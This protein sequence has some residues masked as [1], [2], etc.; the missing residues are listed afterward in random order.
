MAHRFA[1]GPFLLDTRVG[2]L[3]NA[4]EPV[5]VGY[6]AI[7]LLGAFLEKPGTVLSK[8]DLVEVVWEGAAVE[9]SNLSVQI[10][11]LRKAL[12]NQP[13]GG[14]WIATIPRVGYRFAGSVKT[15]DGEAPPTA[16][17]TG[18]APSRPSIAV[19]PFANLGDDKQEDYFAD[20]FVDDLITGL[21]RIRWLSV[22]A[23]NSS[24]TYKNRPTDVRQ[25]GRELGVRYI[26]EGGVRR[27]GDRIRINAQLVEAETGKHLWADRFE[28]Q[29]DSVFDLQDEITDKVVALV[30]PNIQRV[31]IERSRRKRPGSLDAYDL[32]LR[33][34]P[35]TLSQMP[36]DAEVAIRHLEEALRFEP[37]YPAAHAMLAWC[38]EWRYARGGLA[39]ADKAKALHHAHAASGIEV[40][41][42]TALAIA[43]FVRAILSRDSN[44][45]IP[46][47]ARALE[48][49]PSCATAM[50]LGGLTHAMAGD[51]EGALK[52]AERAQELSPFDFLAYQAH[53]A[54]T[55][56]AIIEGRFADAAASSRKALAANG[57]LSSLYFVA[58]AAH[59]LAGDDAAARGFAA[60]GL[61]RQENFRLR[62]FAEVMA[63]SVS[64]GLVSAGKSLGLAY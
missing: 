56:A 59:G 32:Y 12:G 7:R 21:S 44:S 52:L 37:N 55:L 5:V 46:L 14:E 57:N 25:I 8:T 38:I 42:A 30:E 26:L 2:A 20:G 33:A 13:G 28:G 61:R 63:P 18:E 1:F 49:N 58:A 11:V 35:L 62:F 50:Y 51:A 36:A 6:R 47:I 54:R 10:A 27:L 22:I 23:R 15:E 24:F 4:G 34:V 41:D 40:D 19:L 3:L 43:A 45:A 16:A 17:A 53:F 48:L 31:E 39:D 29:N 60:D 9:E 64:G